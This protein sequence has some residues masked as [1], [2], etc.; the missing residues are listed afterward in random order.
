ML[1]IACIGSIRLYVL[2][3]LWS[4]NGLL[5]VDAWPVDRTALESGVLGLRLRSMFICCSRIILGAL[6]SGLI[7]RLISGLVSGLVSGL[8]RR[9]ASEF[10]VLVA[11]LRLRSIVSRLMVGGLLLVRTSSRLENMSK[12]QR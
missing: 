10:N 1:R 12:A 8:I 4:I 9:L 6:I 2:H 7:S 11:W 3:W 5:L